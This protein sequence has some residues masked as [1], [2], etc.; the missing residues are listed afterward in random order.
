MERVEF[1]GPI[2]IPGDR[3]IAFTNDATRTHAEEYLPRLTS[4][5]I[6]WVS[7]TDEDE[8]LS[9]AEMADLVVERFFD[10]LLSE[11]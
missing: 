4:D 9:S 10:S 3:G 8:V 2:R 6:R 1:E 7:R 5:G 11:D